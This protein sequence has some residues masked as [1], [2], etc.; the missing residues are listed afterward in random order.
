MAHDVATCTRLPPLI[1]LLLIVVCLGGSI[2]KLI[3]LLWFLLK[4]ILNKRVLCLVAEKQ[5]SSKL[6]MFFF[7]YHKSWS[8]QRL[9]HF[10]INC[11]SRMNTLIW[12][13][14]VNIYLKLRIL[15]WYRMIR[16]ESKH[17]LSSCWKIV[18]CFVWWMIVGR[19]W[20]Y[21]AMQEQDEQRGCVHKE[22]EDWCHWSIHNIRGWGSCRWGLQC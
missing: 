19:C 11:R 2:Q 10:K 7:I 3:F 12:T 8:H 16:W 20:G 9:F 14:Q 1:T 4:L 15:R 18:R 21:V 5:V 13:T 17:A 6:Y 22:G